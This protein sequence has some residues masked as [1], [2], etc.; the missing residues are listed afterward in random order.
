VIA[1][2]HGRQALLLLDNFEQVV[3]AAPAVAQVLAACPGVKALVTSRTLLRVRG[4]R[5]FIVPPLALP[6]RGGQASREALAQCPSIALFV[7]RAAAAQPDFGLTDATAP[8]VAEICRRLDGLP[9]AIELAAARVR[10]LSP[11]ALLGRLEQ[12]PWQVLAAGPRDLPMRQQTLRHTLAW[13]YDLLD[14]A[15]R[16]AF[17]CFAVFAGGWTLDA[18]ESVVTGAGPEQRA[19]M[20]QDG[21]APCS[22]LDLLESLMDKS[23]I[24]RTEGIAPHGQAVGPRYAM[25]E[26]I[27]EYGLECLAARGLEETVQRR[28][29]LHYL[30]LAEQAKARLTGP[31]QGEWLA[32][33]AQDH[34]NL[35][36]ALRWACEGTTPQT[37][38]RVAEGV[39]RATGAARAASAVERTE[40]GL[41][42]AGAL[43][44]YW[45]L[46]GHIGEGRAWSESLLA[47]A[48][49]E[50]TDSAFR[51]MRVRAVNTAGIMAVMQ[52]DLDNAC[53]FHEEALALWRSLGDDEGIA[54]A[55]NNLGMV[56]LGQGD[57]ERANVYYQECLALS[58]ASGDRQ[59]LAATLSNLGLVARRQGD[60]ARAAAYHEESMAIRRTLGDKW[61]IAAS[62]NNLASLAHFQGDAETGVTLYHASL[63]L[64][65]QLGDKP[66]VMACL[67]GLA[68][69]A[70]SQG[71]PERA[72]RLWGAVDALREETGV[73]LE[74]ATGGDYDR[75]AG[76]VPASLPDKVLRAQWAAGRRM[77]L[78]EAICYA[79]EPA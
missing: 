17:A 34:E 38:E 20:G 47:R 21:T 52:G 37:V 30:E 9:L 72:A 2:L 53:R 41:R 45:W 3:G 25:L 61:G 4:E 27:R 50:Q 7:E 6:A 66:G 49:S 39:P 70:R 51:R 57:H 8:V 59:G 55:L 28:H 13:S 76:D 65:A 43:W 35:R 42:L 31:E 40:V 58:R 14:A 74:T 75:R 29:A 64:M 24:Y 54:A 60:Y 15:E 5:E 33:L 10:L 26:T 16:D 77:T 46:H 36:A 79:C 22:G 73:A 18:A 19:G 68:Q 44:R 62:Q 63:D 71:Q 78:E 23:L 32:R 1:W 69:V 12:A 11:A 48:G 67:E 56:A